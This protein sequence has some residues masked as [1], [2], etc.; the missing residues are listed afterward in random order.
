MEL[1]VVFRDGS[2]G[3]IHVP[4]WV[5]PNDEM[6]AIERRIG[7]YANG[8]ATLSNGMRVRIDEIRAMRAVASEPVAD[9]AA[10]S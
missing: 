4:M 7:K 3:M 1:E 9:R 6:D 2:R 5:S 8:W 10:A